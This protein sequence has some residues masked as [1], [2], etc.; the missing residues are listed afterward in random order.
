MSACR[1]PDYYEKL[2]DLFMA[3]I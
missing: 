1:L 3:D 2:E